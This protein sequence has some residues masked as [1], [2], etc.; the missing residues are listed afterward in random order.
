L[1][2]AHFACCEDETHRPDPAADQEREA[3]GAAFPDRAI[4]SHHREASWSWLA[5]ST[6]GS[7]AAAGPRQTSLGSRMRQSA[8]RGDHDEET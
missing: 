5:S 7:S 3:P 8:S 4:R 2:P 1:R 6:M